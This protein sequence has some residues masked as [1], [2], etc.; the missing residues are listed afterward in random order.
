MVGSVQPGLPPFTPRA[1]EALTDRFQHPLEALEPVPN[2]LIRYPG[3]RIQAF[4]EGAQLVSQGRIGDLTGNSREYLGVSGANTHQAFRTKRPVDRRTLDVN[5]VP[6]SIRITIVEGRGPKLP[7]AL[8]QFALL[9]LFDPRLGSEPRRQ[10]RRY[11]GDLGGRALPG[12]TLPAWPRAPGAPGKRFGLRR[13]RIE[14][15]RPVKG[16]PRVRF[17]NGPDG[18]GVEGG[19]TDPHG[20]RRAKPVQD[21]AALPPWTAGRVH[22]KRVLI[23]PLVAGE[24]KTGHEAYLRFWA[25]R[26][27]ALRAAA[28]RTGAVLVAARLAAGFG[29]VRPLLFARAAIPRLGAGCGARAATLARGAGFGGWVGAAFRA[30]AGVFVPR[31]IAG[32][33]AR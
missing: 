16:D 26:G 14:D 33:E 6:V 21:T 31:G 8:A 28:L 17:F 11:R 24:S 4:G 15:L 13:V 2:F 3:I 7:G 19:P 5:A 10:P 12:L 29:A 1:P 18:C 9:L 30:R 27:A 23:T 20:R 22:E 25:F 32:S